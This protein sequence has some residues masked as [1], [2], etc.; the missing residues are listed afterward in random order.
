MLNEIPADRANGENACN[1]VK[2]QPPLD[3]WVEGTEGQGKAGN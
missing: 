3:S 1:S 2:D